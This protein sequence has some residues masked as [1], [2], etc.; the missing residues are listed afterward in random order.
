MVQNGFSTNYFRVYT[1]RDLVGVELA[2]A[3]KNVIALAAGIA[4]GIEA[5]VNAKASLVTRGLVE[6]TRLGVALGASPDTFR[7]GRKTS[8]RVETAGSKRLSKNDRVKSQA[9]SFIEY[10]FLTKF[11]NPRLCGWE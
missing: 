1:S 9:R 3:A 8:P 5:G 11:N 6:L 7:G 2:G 4:D 10:L